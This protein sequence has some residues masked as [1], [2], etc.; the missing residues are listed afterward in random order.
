MDKITHYFR[1]SYFLLLLCL[2][3]TLFM[4]LWHISVGAK[5]LTFHQIWEAIF[6][7]HA[8]NFNHIIIW[9]LRIPRTIIALTVG[10]SLAVAGALMQAMTRN[11]LAEPSIL[12]L[13]HGASFA[14]VIAISLFGIT[15]YSVLPLIATLGALIAVLLVWGITISAQ[16]GA[17]ALTLILSGAAITAFLAAG[18]TLIKLADN[19]TFDQLRHWLVGSLSGRKLTVFWYALPWVILGITISLTIARQITTFA[20]GEETATGLGVKV[21]RLKILVL[22]SVISLTAASVAMVGP[23]GFI[24]LV[25]PHIVKLLVG[26]D[27]QRIIPFSIILGGLYLLLID[28]IART[29]ISPIDIT[30]GIMTAIFG[31]PL[32]IW[33]VRVKL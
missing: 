18:I 21:K 9:Q 33:L 15:D 2:S 19:D 8:N 10:A 3:V 26:Y 22:I 5:T 4:A 1:S 30:T 11:P 32:F 25:I 13:M 31:A 28:I 27:Y 24:G 23:L 12:G 17:T 7:Y 16:N 14:A 29:I 6:H 20:L